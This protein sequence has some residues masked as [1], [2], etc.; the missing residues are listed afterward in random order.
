M[1]GKQLSVRQLWK[2]SKTIM[3]TRREVLHNIGICEKNGTYNEHVDPFDPN[4]ALPVTDKY[5]YIKMPLRLKI[6]WAF[7]YHFGD[8]PFIYYDAIVTKRLRVYGRKNLKGIKSAICTCNHVYRYDTF[9]CIYALRGHKVYTTAAFFNN[10]KG[11]FGEMMRA[12]GMMPIV[13]NDLKVMRKFNQ[14]IED[15]MEHHK[16]VLFFPEQGMW[17]YYPKPR[18]YLNGA[19]HYAVKHSVPIIPIFIAFRDSGKKD[20]EG[21]TIK[22]SDMFIMNPIY[23]QEGLSDKENIDY[24]RKKNHEM[25]VAKYEEYYKQKYVL[26]NY[27]GTF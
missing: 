4:D 22:Y 2:R 10:L 19:Y 8:L 1:I 18:P 15:H 21:L 23:P 20:K 6:K 26:E 13:D 25:C 17:W 9:N 11:K 3:A 14:A 7:L 27:T 16:Y 5:P 12:G 24:M